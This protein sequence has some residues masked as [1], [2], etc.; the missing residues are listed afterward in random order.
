M[1]SPR[2]TECWSY[3]EGVMDAH[4]TFHDWGELTQPYYC[5]P[6]GVTLGQVRAIVVKRL[7]ENP[8]RLHHSASS[9]VM[10]ALHDAFTPEVK[11]ENGEIVYYC[12]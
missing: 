8:E 5:K 11:F 4:Q 10:N 7:K 6:Q 12:P 2:L 3:L 9:Q 1:S